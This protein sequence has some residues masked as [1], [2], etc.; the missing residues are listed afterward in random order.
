MTP[1]GF[2]V[3][4]LWSEIAGR[5]ADK[6]YSAVQERL[7]PGHGD[8]AAIHARYFMRQRLIERSRDAAYGRGL[9]GV[10]QLVP[11]AAAISFVAESWEI[12]EFGA[13]AEVCSKL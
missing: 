12:D 4:V 3:T 1:L 5:Y 6:S 9:I 7:R 13:S 8:Q 11:T 10:H 2:K